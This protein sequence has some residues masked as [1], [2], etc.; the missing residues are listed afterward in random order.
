MLGAIHSTDTLA[1]DERNSYE[2]SLMRALW[3]SLERSTRASVY[4]FTI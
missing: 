1:G 2:R 4:A 3:V